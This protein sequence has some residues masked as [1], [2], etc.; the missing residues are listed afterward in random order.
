MI[1]QDEEDYAFEQMDFATAT[2]YRTRQ[3]RFQPVGIFDRV[4]FSWR[5]LWDNRRVVQGER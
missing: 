3:T 5:H 2:M 1:R 4:V